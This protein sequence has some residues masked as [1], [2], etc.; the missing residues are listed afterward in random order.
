[1]NR[2]H[3]YNKWSI[4][5]RLMKIYICKGSLFLTNKTQ[6]WSKAA[7]A[8]TKYYSHI[9]YTMSIFSLGRNLCKAALYTETAYPYHGCTWFQTC[10]C[11][12]SL[13]FYPSDSTIILHVCVS[14]GIQIICFSRW[15]LAST[16]WQP[17][18]YSHC[19]RDFCPQIPSLF[20][21]ITNCWGSF[22]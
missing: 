22:L 18:F 5:F 1:M 21:L 4:L 6:S 14:Q 12:T 2:I 8:T 15:E 11:D 16:Q 10:K 7:V 20:V 3:L 19:I 17:H 9:A 13:T